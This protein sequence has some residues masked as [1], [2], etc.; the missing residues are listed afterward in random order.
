MIIICYEMKKFREL[1][2]Q[3]EIEWSE[4][5]NNGQKI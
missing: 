3:H 5:E 2:D 4:R 1:L